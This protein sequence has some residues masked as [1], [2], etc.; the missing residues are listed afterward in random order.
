MKSAFLLLLAALAVFPMTGLAQENLT[1][2]NLPDFL[3]RFETNFGPLESVFRHWL[4]EKLPLRDEAGQSVARRPLA[5]FLLEISHLRQIS[6]QLAGK[7]DDLVLAAKL[8]ISTETVADDL[9]DA[10]QIAYDNDRE[11]LGARLS[12]L[13]TVIAGNKRL[14][15]DYLLALAADRQARLQ[16]LEREVEELRRK[17]KEGKK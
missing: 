15:A 14:L 8:V 4:D 13:E 6:H 2:A 16:Q 10:S 12:G 3:A 5:D 9:F 17:A 7:P 11:E 1:A